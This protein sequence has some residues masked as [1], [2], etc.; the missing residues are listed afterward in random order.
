MTWAGTIGGRPRPVNARAAN[1]VFPVTKAIGLAARTRFG[2]EKTGGGIKKA[3]RLNDQEREEANQRDGGKQTLFFVFFVTIAFLQPSA[4]AAFDG[5][6]H[7]AT[8][9]PMRVF[10]NIVRNV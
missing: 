7:Q 6:P 9:L 1:G 3:K 2:T 10:S 8:I 4:F 5:F